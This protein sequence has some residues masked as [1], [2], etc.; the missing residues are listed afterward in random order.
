MAGIKEIQQRIKSIQETMKITSAMYT[1][2]SS[3]LKKAR[4]RLEESAPYFSLLQTTIAS[5][6]DHSPDIDH[7]FFDSRSDKAEKVKGYV[8]ITGDK[9]MCGA[10]NH[11]AIKLAEELCKNKNNT[12][13]TVGQMGKHYF[14][15]KNASIE[16][17]FL[18]T[19]Q[20]PNVHRAGAISEMFITMFLN[21]YIDEVYMIYTESISQMKCEPRLLKLLPLEKAHF[22]T[23]KTADK[24]NRV[25]KYSPSPEAVMDALVPNYLRGIIFGAL[26]ESFSSEQSSR[27]MAM[28]AATKN[29]KELLASLSLEYNRARQAAIT[30][31]ITEIVGGT[32]ALIN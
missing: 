4:K 18:Y 30:Q 24:Y 29:A 26:I 16:T 13:F 23:D 15:K 14:S 7:P 2:S 12:L 20:H 8:L 17:E 25:I 9:G 31:E 6:L 11:N 28:D 5:I 27:M 1:I 22:E 3:K 21:G 10:Y 32:Q 19:A